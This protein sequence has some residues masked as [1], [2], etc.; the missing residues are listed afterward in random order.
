MD[1]IINRK[2]KKRPHPNSCADCRYGEDWEGYPHY[3]PAED[4]D[5]VSAGCNLF[6][7]LLGS[8]GQLWRYTCPKWQKRAWWQKAIYFVPVIGIAYWVFRREET[9]VREQI[10]RKA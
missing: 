10:E 9:E 1:Y 7:V 2:G 8:T 6:N 5:P 3:L 4:W